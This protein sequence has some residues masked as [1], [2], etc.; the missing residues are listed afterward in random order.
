MQSWKY[1]IQFCV[2]GC[3]IL[4][5]RSFMFGGKFRISK[6]DISPINFPLTNGTISC[7]DYLSST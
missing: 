1:D 7:I 2:I 6:S 3:L 4:N 5:S